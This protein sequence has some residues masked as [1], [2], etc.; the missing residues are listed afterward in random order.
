MQVYPDLPILTAQPACLDHHYLYGFCYTRC[1]VALWR[2]RAMD[3]IK[4]SFSEGRV[5]IIVGGTGLYI[6]ALLEGLSPIPEIDLAILEQTRIIP[7][8]EIFAYACAKDPLIK[9]R[10]HSSD[11]QRIKRALNVYLQTQKSLFEWHNF[12]KIPFPYL[13][14][15]TFVTMDRSVLYQRINERFLKMIDLGAIK[16]VKKATSLT[17]GAEQAIGYSEI[18]DYL[19]GQISLETAIERSQ[20]RTRQYAKRQ[21]TWFRHKI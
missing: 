2:D 18:Q 17:P 12:P 11:F 7:D 20:T 14:D 9:E 10:L 8:H 21:M 13:Y 19:Q 5:P 1:T 16:E 15:V 4:K 6:K 3:M